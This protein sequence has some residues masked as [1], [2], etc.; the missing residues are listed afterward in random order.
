MGRTCDNEIT[1][2]D[3]T[4]LAVQDI[5]TAWKVYEKALKRGIGH[6]MDLMA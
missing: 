6:K 5:A 4:G 3:S 2:F 1:V